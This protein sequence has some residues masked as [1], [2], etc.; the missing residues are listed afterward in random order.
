MIIGDMNLGRYW[1]KNY[2]W[3][4]LKAQIIF[5][6]IDTNFHRNQQLSDDYLCCP[7]GFCDFHLSQAKFSVVPTS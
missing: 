5:H 6:T 7:P 1:W 2:I 4:K 3:G